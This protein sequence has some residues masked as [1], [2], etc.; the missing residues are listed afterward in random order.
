MTETVDFNQPIEGPSR[1]VDEGCPV[2]LPAWRKVILIRHVDGVVG[3][4][5]DLWIAG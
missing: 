2:S 4:R 3:D 5:V 1:L